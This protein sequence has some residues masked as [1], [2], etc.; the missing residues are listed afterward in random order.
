MTVIDSVNCGMQA[1]CQVPVAA[2]WV[3]VSYDKVMQMQ[4]N[5][6]PA[7]SMYYLPL[8]RHHVKRNPQ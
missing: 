6:V 4:C 5:S 8:D 7:F 3:L 1:Q 2:L